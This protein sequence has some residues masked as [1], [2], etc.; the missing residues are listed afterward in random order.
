MTLAVGAFAGT[1]IDNLV[2]VATQMAATEQRRH[3]RIAEG[4]IAATVVILGLAALGGAALSSVPHRLLGLLGLLPLG[5]AVRGVVL[6]VRHDADDRRVP[7]AAGFLSSAA[8]TFALSADNVA[9][10]LP[11]LA[12]GSVTSGAASVTIWILLDL[13]LV[14]LSMVVGRHPVARRALER[15]GAFALPIVYAFVGIAIILRSGLVG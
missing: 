11:I 3:R 4:Q 13:G 6:L 8:V 9:V 15:L 1:N 10:Y 2:T 7:V 12:T 14:G 5:L